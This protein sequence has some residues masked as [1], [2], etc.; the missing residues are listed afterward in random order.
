MKRIFLLCCLFLL[1]YSSANATLITIG[2]AT[3][4]GSNYNLIWDND[5]SLIW[6]DYTDSYATW[7]TQDNWASGLNSGSALTIN[8]NASYDVT[9]SAGG[10]WD[11][12]SVGELTDLYSEKTAAGYASNFD[13]LSSFNWYWTS[14]QYDSGNAFV[15]SMQAGYAITST[16]DN[17]GYSGWLAVRSGQVA[18]VNPV[19]EPATM[20]LF[21]LGLLGHAGVSRKK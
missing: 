4:G 20:L 12:G 9:W 5:D 16:M 11:L 13:N 8:I 10:N 3:Y 15:F 19:P 17:N 1:L 14:T 6:L 2:T 7:Y 21:A 18:E